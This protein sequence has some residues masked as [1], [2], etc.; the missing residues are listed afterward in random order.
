MR[1]PWEG[2]IKSTRWEP[3]GVGASCAARCLRSNF[4]VCPRK[5]KSGASAR[6]YEGMAMERECAE[7]E[8]G[9][10]LGDLLQIGTRR[11]F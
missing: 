6:G 3:V 9:R 8:P 4:N 7:R 1:G 11:V 10:P 2:V 5:W